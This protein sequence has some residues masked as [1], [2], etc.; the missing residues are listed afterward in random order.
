MPAGG[1][2]RLTLNYPTC[3]RPTGRLSDPGPVTVA[4]D[5]PQA[6]HRH[7]DAVP[8]TAA[9]LR[10]LRGDP[11][12]GEAAVEALQP[13]CARRIHISRPGRLSGPVLA[14]PRE[15]KFS[16]VMDATTMSTMEKVLAFASENRDMLATLHR[17]QIAL[18]G[19]H[20]PLQ[21]FQTPASYFNPVV[22][23]WNDSANSFDKQ[24]PWEESES[25]WSNLRSNLISV[26]G[27][28]TCQVTGAQNAKAVHV[29]PRSNPQAIKH[30]CEVDHVQNGLFLVENIQRAFEH[31]KICFLKSSINDEIILHILDKAI[32]K[33]LVGS[34]QS[35]TF[36]QWDQ[37]PLNIFQHCPSLEILSRH[38][39]SSLQRAI[40]KKWITKED[41]DNL[42]P[43][44]MI[45]PNQR[46][47]VLNQNIQQ[48]T[49]DPGKTLLVAFSWL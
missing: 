35:G 31:R 15:I 45:D 30:I 2:L 18:D 6:S 19:T 46:I 29:A 28:P 24:D 42:Q 41:F 38:T 39:I 44:A 33:K 1:P 4:A 17:F 5:T 16:V 20:T 32:F 47:A 10:L 11:S 37:K 26:T 22:D 13:C 25:A 49:S 36:K 14:G 7:G 12:R 3:Q 48:H 43:R 40:T 21:S 27:V 34:V 23:S 9:A 8:V